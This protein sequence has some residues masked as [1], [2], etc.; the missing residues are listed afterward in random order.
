LTAKADP[1]LPGRA[2]CFGDDNIIVTESVY[3]GDASLIIPGSTV[4]PNGAVAIADG[5]YPTVFNNESVDPSFGI[6]SPI[7]LLQLTRRGKDVSRLAVPTSLL[8]SSFSSKSE[9]AINLSAEGMALTFMGYVA[10]VNTFDVSN[11][12]TLAKSTTGTVYHSFGL[13]E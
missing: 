4:L 5:S 1:P 11:S 12:T 10:P 3:V 2:E 9:L 7:Y 13:S 6:T 8:T